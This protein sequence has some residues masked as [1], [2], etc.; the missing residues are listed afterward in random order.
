MRWKMTS[1]LREV[2]QDQDEAKLRS[3]FAA[4]GY[5]LGVH[6]HSP[7]AERIVLEEVLEG[8]SNGNLLLVFFKDLG[9][10]YSIGRDKCVWRE[11]IHADAQRLVRGASVM[12]KVV[13]LL[14]DELHMP[15]PDDAMLQ[16]NEPP[17]MLL[18]SSFSLYS[19][20]HTHTHIGGVSGGWM[21]R[22][23]NVGAKDDCQF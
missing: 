7:S 17:C 9:G 2:L 12:D 6:C 23:A 21:E 8:R 13:R 16:V 1:L 4:R 15:L 18:S 20:T 3:F 5:E 11:L 10:R 19:H 14:V 22:A